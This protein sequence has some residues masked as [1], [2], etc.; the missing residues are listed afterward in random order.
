MIEGP[1]DFTE[2]RSSLYK[3]ALPGLVTIGIVE[4]FL[5]SHVNSRDYVFKELC[6]LMDW[7]F[8]WQVTTS[9]SFVAIALA[10]VVIQQLQHFIWPFK[11]TWSKDLVTLWKGNSLLYIST[12]PKLV[13][14]DIVLM[15][16]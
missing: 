14:I 5:I 12:L 9:P 3:T 16:I 13:A 2:R 1:C 7:S 8:L 15:D 6:D 4:M 11:K 10:V